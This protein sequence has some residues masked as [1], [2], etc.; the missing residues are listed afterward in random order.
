M[1]EVTDTYGMG[2]AQHAKEIQAAISFQ[3]CCIGSAVR[4][5][6]ALEGEGMGRELVPC[7]QIE[8]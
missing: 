7:K 3:G 8:K 2:T 5:L 6:M 1:Q 4:S